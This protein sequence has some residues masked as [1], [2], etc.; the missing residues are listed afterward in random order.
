MP[1]ASPCSD[2]GDEVHEGPEAVEEEACGHL[3]A[4]VRRKAGIAELP[5][6][7]MAGEERGDHLR[8]V[9]RPPATFVE[10][11]KRLRHGALLLLR[12]TG[13]E[14]EA[15]EEAGDGARVTRDAHGDQGALRVAKDVGEAL[16]HDVPAPPPRGGPE[17]ARRGVVHHE[18]L[19]TRSVPAG[20]F[21]HVRHRDRDAT[22][23]LHGVT[24]VSPSLSRS[25][26]V[27][28]QRTMRVLCAPMRLEKARST[29]LCATA[30]RRSPL[31]RRCHLCPS[32]H[33][34]TT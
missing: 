28:P 25:S 5:D 8:E 17:R 32:A 12:G 13:Q 11:W 15:V 9:V 23:A 16:E 34:R 7:G 26:R 4:W 18:H 27:P 3:V 14:V 6:P 1:D 24:P 31:P 19:A 33:P 22:Q 10:A 2:G 30:T 20:E 29:S 21:P